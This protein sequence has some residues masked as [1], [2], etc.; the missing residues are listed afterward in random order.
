M[1]TK[2][3]ILLSLS[4]ICSQYYDVCDE[5][6]ATYVEV[7]FAIVPLNQSVLLVDKMTRS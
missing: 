6:S 1:S 7:F 4:F 5:S 3:D 2:L